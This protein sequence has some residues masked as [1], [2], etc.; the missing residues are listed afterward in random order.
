VPTPP[1]HRLRPAWSRSDGLVPRVVVQPLQRFLHTEASG[2]ILL[3]AAAVAALVW[4][5][6]PWRDAYRTLWSTYATIGVGRFAL[7]ESL[8]HVVNDLGMAFFFF[9]VGLEIKR[10]LVHGD[11]RERRTALL[12]A[13]AALGGMVIPAG[14]YLAINAGGEGRAG[15]GI[16]MATDIAFSLGVLTLVAR[17]APVALKSF[18]LALAIVDDIG[19]IIVIAVFYSAGVEPLWLAG[20]FVGL[21]AIVGLRRLRVRWLLPYVVLAAAVWLA[22]FESGVHATLAGVA[23]GLLT[24]AVPFQRPA[25]VRDAV[26]HSLEQPPLS[27]DLEDEVDEM[28]FLDVAAMSREAVSPLARLEQVLHPWTAF[29][30]LPLF[31]LAN[32]GVELSGLPG[33]DGR[34]VAAGV[35]VG[36]LVGKPVGIVLASVLAVRFAGAVLPRG[37]SWSQITAVGL[38]GGIGF[39]VSLFVAG[40]AFTGPLG[41]LGDSARLGVLTASLLAGVI[42]AAVLAVGNRRR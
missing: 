1:Q 15:W 16:P 38:L 27:D 18:L 36:L 41:P 13:A 25:M 34:L 19:A 2:G 6:S 33:G 39:T 10:E 35:V 5:N 40:L 24:P 3:L 21:G 14:I 8:L 32:A 22:T 9:V 30:V 17:S 4:A 29:V 37:V 26:T 31:A 42:G 11:L 23:L 12:P 7:H 20:A 28:A